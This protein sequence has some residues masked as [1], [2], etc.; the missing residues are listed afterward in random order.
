MENVESKAFNCF[1]VNI[2]LNKNTFYI[3]KVNKDIAYTLKA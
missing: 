1:Y 3:Q 2:E